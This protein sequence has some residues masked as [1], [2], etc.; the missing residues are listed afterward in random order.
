MAGDAVPGPAR[1]DSRRWA[2]VAA[3]TATFAVLLDGTAAVMA[4]PGPAA[5]LGFGFGG[6]QG[7]VVAHALALAALVSVGGVV[8]DRLGT[9]RAFR[10]GAVL[11]GAG[12]VASGAAGALLAL[13]LAR[14]VQGIGSGLLLATAAKLVGRER[15]TDAS[16][17]PTTAATRGVREPG[18]AEASDPHSAAANLAGREQGTDASGSPTAAADPV[19]RRQGAGEASDP[20][21]AAANAVGR[22]EASPPP[23]AAKRVGREYR[24]VA[25]ALA[26][27][28]GL[29]VGGALAEVDWRLVFLAVLPVGVLLLAIGH[30]HLRAGEPTPAADQPRFGDR[31]SLATAAVAFTSGALGLGTVF[32]EVLRLRDGHSPLDVLLRLLPLVA[33][34][35]VTSAL[36]RWL[37]PR[38]AIPL[39]T[40]ALLVALGAA[41]VTGPL[42]PLGLVA[43]GVGLGLGTAEVTRRVNQTY[44]H[45]GVAVGVPALGALVHHRAIVCAVVGAVVSLAVF[46]WVDR[47]GPTADG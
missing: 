44:H 29:V 35:V 46:A 37:A 15:G 17:P 26:V 43:L 9:G 47:G 6:Q 18:M 11:F 39:A 30:V 36:A 21:S 32:P 13:V 12:A 38:P 2:T 31:A 20:R 40:S 45:V 10:L 25:G 3:S 7:V 42:V 19:G 4:L 14:V 27:A 22:A 34:V 16:G 28:L 23:A 1:M 5:E 41:L 24:S 8:A 33:A